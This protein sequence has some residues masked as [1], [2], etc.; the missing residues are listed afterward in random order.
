MGTFAKSMKPLLK[1]CVNW[2]RLTRTPIVVTNHIYDD[3]SA[4]FPS[5]EKCMPGGK[6]AIYL[7]SVTIQLARKAAKDDGG[8][9][10]DAD[11]AASQ[12][13]FSGVIIR[14]LAAKNRFIK[15]YIE[16]ELYLSFSRGLDKYYGLLE[17]MKGMGVV[18]SNG[19]TYTDWQ[20][21]KLGFYKNWR[22]DT[23]LFEE[24]LLPELESRIADNWRYGNKI[25]EE[26]PAAELDSE[27]EFVRGI[28]DEPDEE[29]PIEKLKTLKK[30]VSKTIDDFAS[31]EE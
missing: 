30:K 4:M 18:I 11:L 17:I 21:E 25:G 29:T 28:L 1:T 13:S 10:I 15:Q 16:V 14:A 24:R 3:P 12:K 6:A 20:G 2:G 27:D 23:K 26:I 8:K 7:P 19:A 22:K 31:E 9:T 5:L